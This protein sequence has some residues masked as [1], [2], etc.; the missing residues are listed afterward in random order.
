MRQML[1]GKM[2]LVGLVAQFA[3]LLLLSLRDEPE[4]FLNTQRVCCS[5]AV[6]WNPGLW[7]RIRINLNFWIRI[8]EGK[9]C[10]HK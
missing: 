10:P 1:K 5:S 7:I 3:Y 8:Q 2:S 6:L 9:N 4:F